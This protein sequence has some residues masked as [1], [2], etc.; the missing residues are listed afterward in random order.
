MTWLSPLDIG[1]NMGLVFAWLVLSL[2][3]SFRILRFPDL[4][5]EGSFPLGAAVYALCVSH[6]LNILLAVLLSC[7]VAAIP[8]IA[9]AFLHVNFRVNK[10]LSGIIVASI[11]Y[12]L[13]LRLMGGPNIGIIDKPTIFNIPIVEKLNQIGGAYFQVGNIVLLLIIIVLGCALIWFGLYSFTGIKLRAAGSNPDYAQSLGLNA[14]AYIIFGLACSNALAGFS[15]AL[16]SMRQGFADVGM[17]QGLLIMAIASM[18]IGER[19]TPDLG[20]PFYGFVIASAIWGSVVYQ[21]L[22][23]IA[24]RAGLAPTDLKLLTALLALIVIILTFSRNNEGMMEE[25]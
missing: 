9:T 15:G 17:G 13:I 25:K 22:V 16:L 2:S 24:V 10:F 12:S 1:L 11:C 21:T 14:K 8:G 6:G 5:I 7:L 20:M 23:A 18:A 4:T 3:L 19:V